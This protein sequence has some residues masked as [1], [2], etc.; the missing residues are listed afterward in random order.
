M[1]FQWRF[2]IHFTLNKFVKCHHWNCYSLTFLQFPLYPTRRTTPRHNVLFSH[3]HRLNFCLVS[4][5]KSL[6]QSQIHFVPIPFDD[7]SFSQVQSWKW[8]ST[9]SPGKAIIFPDLIC[10]W[11]FSGITKSRQNGARLEG[12][13]NWDHQTSH[14]S[15]V[16]APLS[17]FHVYWVFVS[18]N[19]TY[20]QMNRG[21]KSETCEILSQE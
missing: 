7:K 20:C 8:L 1:I 16:C 13:E 17:H 6:N 10:T 21:N 3:H 12:R 4:S 5:V 11:C 15:S 14:S 2:K 18:L 9:N 19:S